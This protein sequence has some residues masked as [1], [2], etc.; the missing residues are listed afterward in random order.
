MKF[1]TDFVTNSSSSNFII[2]QKGG[3]TDSQKERIISLIEERYIGEKVLTPQSTKMEI[4]KYLEHC[5]EDY[6]S[7]IKK[8][9]K[10][11]KSI[12][13]GNIDFEECDYF[14]DQFYG[15]L[16]DSMK[17]KGRCSI[18]KDDLSY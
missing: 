18:I 15:L 3:L 9:L 11:G 12:Y 6:A 4:Q 13:E 17:E 1:R 14:I 8:A 2:A 7:E 10:E 16:F 5:D